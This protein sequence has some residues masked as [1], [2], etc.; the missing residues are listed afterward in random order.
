MIAARSV[1]GGTTVSLTTDA[2]DSNPKATPKG[3]PGIIET[4][5]PTALPTGPTQVAPVRASLLAD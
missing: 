3:G 1:T 5:S 2:V 4:P